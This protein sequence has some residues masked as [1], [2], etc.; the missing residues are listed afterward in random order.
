VLILIT[1]KLKKGIAVNHS[2]GDPV[3][4]SEEED[5]SGYQVHHEYTD[6]EEERV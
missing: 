4:D 5:S 3:Y 6:S 1:I 2:T